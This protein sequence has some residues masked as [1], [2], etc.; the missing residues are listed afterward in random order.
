MKRNPTNLTK[1]SSAFAA[2]AI[3]AALTIPSAEAAIITIAP[4]NVTASSEIGGTFNR[5][6]DY[7]VNGNGLTGGQHTSA[8]EPN[9]WLSAGTGFGGIDADPSVT[10]DLGV[11]LQ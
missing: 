6:D 2:T 5:L 9:M 1:I 11:E 8:V 7:I 10:F 3:A 4:A